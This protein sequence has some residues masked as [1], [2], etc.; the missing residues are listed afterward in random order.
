MK[1][2]SLRLKTARDLKGWTL[3]EAAFNLKMD[4][5]ELGLLE[6]N[7]RKIQ[8]KEI[9]QISKVYDIPRNWF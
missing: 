3:R 6:A 7:M 1:L 5:S 8:S 2:Q 4:H 9:D